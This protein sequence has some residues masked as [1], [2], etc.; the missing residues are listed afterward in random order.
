MLLKMAYVQEGLQHIGPALYYLNLYYIA[1]RDKT[2][3]DK[4]D[5]LATK[6]NLKG[7]EISETSGAMSFYND[8]NLYISVAIAALMVLMMSLAAYTKLKLNKRPI[9]SFS[10]LIV[11]TIALFSNLIYAG[12]MAT[13]IVAHPATYVMKG[14]S[15]AAAV[16]DI[17]SDGHRVNIIGKKDVWLKVSWDGNTGY[18]KQNAMLPIAL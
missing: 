6:Y 11:L 10:I 7:Y 17:I 9:A 12:G 1:T 14:P 15:A 2:T 16:I 3:L 8:Y 4:M 5:E 13:A 18:I